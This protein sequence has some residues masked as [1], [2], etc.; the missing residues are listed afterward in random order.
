MKRVLTLLAA[1]FTVSSAAYAQSESR[2]SEM[3]TSSDTCTPTE[4]PPTPVVPE[5]SNLDSWDFM[6][7]PL[8]PT[9]SGTKS[10]YLVAFLSATDPNRLYV[11]GIDVGLGR[12]LFA[13]TMSKRYTALLTQRAG[14]DIG[15]FQM[16][17]ASGGGSGVSIDI[18]GPTPPPPPPNIHDPYVENYG[19]L[20]W[21]VAVDLHVA[22][23]KL[24]N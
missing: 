18:E 23:S 1:V 4:Y 19:P 7:T 24:H 5:A 16:T 11:Y 8:L 14:L 20:A 12:I 9:T 6:S 17:T 13:A 3:T 15:N 2:A 21:H 22:T 10:L